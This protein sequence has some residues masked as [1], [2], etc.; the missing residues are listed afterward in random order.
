MSQDKLP[1]SD[2][3]R[4]WAAGYVLGN[5]DP[6]EL[7]HFKTLLS[8]N[9][10]LRAEVRALQVSLRLLPQGLESA[11]LPPQLGDRILSA[12]AAPTA[13][14]SRR[15]FWLILLAGV[16]SFLAVLFLGL[17][18]LRLRRMLSLTQ[19]SIPPTVVTLL[20][21]PNSRLIA[22]RS[23]TADQPA[24][25]LLFTPGKWQEVVISLNDLPP[26]PPDQIYRLWLIPSKGRILPC[27]EFKPDAAGRV[28][29]TLISAGTLPKNARA[30]GV[31]VTHDPISAPVQ[32]SGDRIL[33][34]KI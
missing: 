32:P 10:V 3:E 29:A 6:E 34:G 23:Q 20:Q 13:A 22:L 8:E 4:E 27:G 26:L 16:F 18:N 17:D 24:G 2:T 25:T 9:S 15:L 30:T 31:F 5:L 21:R 12:Y 11:T 28:F 7:A 33:S 1:L 19:Q 14:P